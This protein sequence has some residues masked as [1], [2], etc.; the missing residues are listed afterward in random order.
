MFFPS[1]ISL[2]QIYSIIHYFCTVTVQT[3]CRVRNQKLN[4]CNSRHKSQVLTGKSLVL[5]PLFIIRNLI[6]SDLYSQRNQKCV[7]CQ[8]VSPTADRLSAKLDGSRG[9][10][11]SVWFKCSLANFAALNTRHESVSAAI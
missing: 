1:I 9:G 5:M 6:V 4:S 8:S 11:T 7:P 3:T 2:Q 10:C